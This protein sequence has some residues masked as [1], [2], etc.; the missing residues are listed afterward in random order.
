MFTILPFTDTW[1]WSLV[2]TATVV[3]TTSATSASKG[4]VVVTSVIEATVVESTSVVVVAT[5][6]ESTSVVVESI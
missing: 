6:V 5:I 4:L 1:S 3:E 2:S